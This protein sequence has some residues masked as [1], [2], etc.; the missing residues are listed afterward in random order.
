MS[1]PPL[2]SWMIPNRITAARPLQS[3]NS[4]D[5]IPY[6]QMLVHRGE[7]VSNKPPCSVPA[8]FPDPPG[9]MERDPEHSRPMKKKGRR[10][11]MGWVPEKCAGSPKDES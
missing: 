1:N 5:T 11:I 7:K 10:Y 8:T 3:R 9:D 2:E 6:R 4:Q